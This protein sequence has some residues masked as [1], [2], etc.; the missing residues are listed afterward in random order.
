MVSLKW[1]IWPMKHIHFFTPFGFAFLLGASFSQASVDS[2]PGERDLQADIPIHNLNYRSSIDAPEIFRRSELVFHHFQIEPESDSQPQLARFE[3]AQTLP[4]AMALLPI[5][6]PSSQARRFFEFSN[7]WDGF[8]DR[9]SQKYRDFS[10]DFAQA[11]REKVS[12]SGLLSRL[13]K[14][15]RASHP[16]QPLRGLRVALD[17]G[18]MGGSDWDARTG[19]WVKDQSGHRISEGVLNLQTALLLEADLVALGANVMI[20]HRELAPVSSVPYERLDLNSFARAELRNVSLASWFQSLLE[21]GSDEASLGNIFGGSTSVKHLFSESSRA[22][23]FILHADLDARSDQIEKFDPDITLIIHYDA[24]VTANLPN[25]VNPQGRD[26]VK[27]YLPGAF[28][29]DEFATREE[30]KNF[31][32]H[33]LDPE[34]WDASLKLAQSVI[35]S[36]TTGL[37]LSPEAYG[38]DKN[39]VPISPGVFARNLA[40]TRKLHSHAI[41]YVE[42]LY[43]NYPGE[44]SAL[45]KTR[46]PLRAG[47]QAIPYSDRVKQVA[48]SLKDSILR[49][50][51]EYKI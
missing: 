14:I 44:F 25:D 49:F 30:R 9:D 36:L 5:L 31:S 39:V 48:D 1:G 51:S 26:A 6:D 43:Y 50:V 24:A 27:T 13:Q 19:K 33:L 4:A 41:T 11:P 2:V 7:R 46:H 34:A 3:R 10:L 20:T 17:P 35:H 42:C 15:A 23:Y 12:P 47:D 32:R 18:H 37:N 21:R 16:N 28:F 29:P 22:N 38:G 45:L 8:L 40:L